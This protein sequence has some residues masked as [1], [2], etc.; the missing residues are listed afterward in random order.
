MASMP[1]SANASGRKVATSNAFSEGPGS[2]ALGAE[3]SG[4]TGSISFASGCG[5]TSFARPALMGSVFVFR[6]VFVRFP[7]EIK[8]CKSFGSESVSQSKIMARDPVRTETL[9][10]VPAT[11]L[12]KCFF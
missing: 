9:F 7:L 3:G 6:S 1:L 8:T 11:C 10:F 12:I 5:L 4:T 2:V